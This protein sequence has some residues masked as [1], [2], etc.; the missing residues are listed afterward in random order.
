MG[1]GVGGS[2]FFLRLGFGRAADDCPE[3]VVPE[4]F[5]AMSEAAGS[6]TSI[7]RGGLQGRPP[8]VCHA[9]VVLRS[10]TASEAGSLS[11]EMPG[12]VAI[13]AVAVQSDCT[14]D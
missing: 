7:P 3:L 1:S 4:R 11:R 8:A 12:V 5:A 2:D 6:A 10:A 9:G 14:Q 13:D